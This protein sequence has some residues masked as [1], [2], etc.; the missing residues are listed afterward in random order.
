MSEPTAHEAAPGQELATVEPVEQGS[1]TPQE[2]WMAEKAGIGIKET[3]DGQ[4]MY[5]IT[6][7]VAAH[8]NLLMPL[9]SVLQVDPNWTPMLRMTR[10]DVKTETY[11]VGYKD[12]QDIHA[13]DARAHW[14][15]AELCGIEARGTKRIPKV[16]PDGAGGVIEY[17]VVVEVTARMR[18]ADGLF[19][20]VT[21]SRDVTYKDWEELERI[22]IEEKAA[23]GN[24]GPATEAQIRKTILQQKNFLY[25]SLETKAFERCVDAFLGMK[26]FPKNQLE[27]PFIAL[28]WAMTAD[29]NDPGSRALVQLQYRDA[30]D[31]LYGP[32]SDG[33]PPEPPPIEETTGSHL[34]PATMLEA[35]DELDPAVGPMDPTTGQVGPTLFPEQREEEQ[36][37]DPA[38]EQ[39]P[40]GSEADMD[41]GDAPGKPAADDSFTIRSD[42]K[43]GF[44]GWTAEQLCGDPGGREHL[45]KMAE[46]AKDEAK[47]DQLLRWLSWVSEKPITM[48]GLGEVPR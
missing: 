15:L 12:G 1:L 6:P 8:A 48:E 31:Q 17:G 28:G 37:D 46:G 22:A 45:V 5:E 19:K 7:Q 30:A 25:P 29:M 43:S 20:Y 39:E 2:R 18:G 33:P 38:D 40:V 36:Q 26:T 3:P 23:R 21:R 41:P 4:R 9:S 35:G 34:D 14:K 27:K 32:E 44:A 42:S 47:R 10:L 13:L 16:A 24:K 11:K